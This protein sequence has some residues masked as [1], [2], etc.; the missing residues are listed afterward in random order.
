MFDILRRIRY[1]DKELQ[2]LYDENLIRETLELARIIQEEEQGG[3]DDYVK[4]V[5]IRRNLEKWKRTVYEVG[6]KMGIDW[7]EALKTSE[8]KERE[9]GSYKKILEIIIVITSLFG[10]GYI[11][12]F[13]RITTQAIATTP[14]II[15]TGILTVILILSLLIVFKK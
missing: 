11:I 7:K 8:Y 14:N 4:F 10:L 15:V 2:K 6:R 9:A 5:R 3:F 12:L 1:I 13:P